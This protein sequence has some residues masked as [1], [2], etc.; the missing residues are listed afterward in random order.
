MLENSE[1]IIESRFAGLF[2]TFR[3]AEETLL[4][5]VSAI[6]SGIARVSDLISQQGKEI[7]RAFS[8]LSTHATNFLTQSE[9]TLLLSSPERQLARG[10]SIVRHNGKVVRHTKD[11]KKGD[12]LDIL[13]SD[14]NI[15]TQII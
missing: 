12:R 9:K 10:Y 8:L 5:A 1:V 6:D 4:R 7:S 2:E 3:R 11:A 14:G 13:V 15:Q